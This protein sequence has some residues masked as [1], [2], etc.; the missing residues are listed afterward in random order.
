M[1]PGFVVGLRH[2]RTAAWI[3]GTHRHEPKVTGLVAGYGRRIPAAGAGARW[4]QAL[5]KSLAVDSAHGQATTQREPGQ[6]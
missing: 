3:R 6:A 2:G 1:L 4:R 5:S